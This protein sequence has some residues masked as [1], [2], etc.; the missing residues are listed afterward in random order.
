[1]ENKTAVI[2]G[3][4]RNI[5]LA[6]AEKF[7][8]IGYNVAILSVS[9]NSA[10]KAAIN[11][12]NTGKKVIGYRCDVTNVSSVEETL[13]QINKHFGGIDILVNSA[14]ILDMASIEDTS[15]E[16]WDNVMAVNLRGTFTMIQKS[17]Q[18]LEK[19]KHP[20]IINLSSNSGRMGGFENGMALSLIHI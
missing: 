17:I 7:Y 5:G 1:M 8:A 16:E 13:E 19:S 9:E 3:G 15:I 11:I 6:I 14:G 12:D 18:Y 2:T 4:S 20:R 10:T